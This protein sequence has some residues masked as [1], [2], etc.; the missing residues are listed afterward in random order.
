MRDHQQQKD[1]KQPM[2]LNHQGSSREK[3]DPIESFM[4]EKIT[5]Q[6][7]QH[8]GQDQ[9]WL[10]KVKFQFPSKSSEFILSPKFPAN[11]QWTQFSNVD[12][13][14]G[15]NE[16]WKASSLI[17]NLVNPVPDN[18]IRMKIGFF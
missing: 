12:S 4:E 17:T 2:R 3:D 9:L 18:K 1:H 10:K 16:L 7:N 13:R 11:G 8:F 14:S 15:S 6:N 5:I